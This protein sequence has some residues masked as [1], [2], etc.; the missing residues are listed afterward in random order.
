ML[1]LFPP[2]G[3]WKEQRIGWKHDYYSMNTG[4]KIKQTLGLKNI[5]YVSWVRIIGSPHRIIAIFYDSLRPNM[6]L[7][8]QRVLKNKNMFTAQML[9]FEN[10]LVYTP[11]IPLEDYNGP[12]GNTIFFTFDIAGIIG[13]KQ[14][15]VTNDSVMFEGKFF[16]KQ[17]IMELTLKD[18]KA[19]DSMSSFTQRTRAERNKAMKDAGKGTGENAYASL[20]ECEINEEED[21]VTFKFLTESTEPIY[22]KDHAFQQSDQD[23]NFTLTPNASKTYEVHIRILKFFEWLKGTRPDT[24]TGPITRLEIKDVLDVADVQVWSNSPS[25]HWQGINYWLSQLDSSIYPTDIAPKFWNQPHLHGNN[26]AFADKHLGGVLRQI[27]FFEEQMASMLTKR[28][29]EKGML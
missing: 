8:T 20:L 11:L 6:P 28:M 10:K 16:H 12:T 1:C 14:N 29:K 22:P 15:Q 19:T 23:S 24:E 21:Y 5:K 7:T 4:E 17:R 3:W 25:F 27:S 2:M 13:N 26:G 9:P 18:L